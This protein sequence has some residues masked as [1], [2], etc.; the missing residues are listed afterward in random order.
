MFV[1]IVSCA[2]TSSVKTIFVL[3]IKF[4]LFFYDFVTNML[5]EHKKNYVNFRAVIVLYWSLAL[6]KLR[7]MLTGGEPQKF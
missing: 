4:P 5:T 7:C 3:S 2:L 1:F 6:L